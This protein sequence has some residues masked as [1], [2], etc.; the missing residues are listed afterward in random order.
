MTKSVTIPDQIQSICML[1]MQNHLPADDAI[2]R[3][4]S[5]MGDVS[6]WEGAGPRLRE[7]GDKQ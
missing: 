3:I 1:Y 7:K 2:K 5:G 6:L 4:L